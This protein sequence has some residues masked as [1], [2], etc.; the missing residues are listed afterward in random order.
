MVGGES[1]GEGN[2]ASNAHQ[3]MGSLFAF[4]KAGVGNPEPAG[5]LNPNGIPPQ[6]AEVTAL[7][8]NPDRT[9]VSRRRVICRQS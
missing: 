2:R 7:S 3:F 6:S 1:W 8:N 9:Y 4:F 5:K